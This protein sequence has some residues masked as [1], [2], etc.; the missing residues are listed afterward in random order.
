MLSWIG[1]L[2]TTATEYVFLDRDGVL[3]RDRPDYVKNR[4]EFQFYPD[5]L[6]ALQWLRQRH[7]AVI[8]ISNQSA[9]N[10]GYTDWDSFWQV[11]HAMIGE[12]RRAGGDILAAYYCPHRPDENCFCRKPSPEMLLN[13]AKTFGTILSSAAMIG[14]RSTD[15]ET[16]RQAGCRAVLLERSE[17][18]AGPPGPKVPVECAPDDR[19]TSLWAAAQ[20]LFCAASDQ[21]LIYSV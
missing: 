15:L 10:R 13:A 18:P 11:H 3:N 9:L 12:A 7:V 8:V 20:G 2:E 14:D 17:A 1:N 16:A 21:S 4:D 5:A 6:A 19:F